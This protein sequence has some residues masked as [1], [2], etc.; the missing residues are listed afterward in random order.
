MSIHSKNAIVRTAAVCVRRTVGSLHRPRNAVALVRGLARYPLEHEAAHA[1]LAIPAATFAELFPEF[2]TANLTVS[3][4]D[5]DRHSWNVRLHEAIYLG[6]MVAALGARQIFE[7]GTFDGGTTRTLAEQSPADAVVHTIDLPESAFDA[8]QTPNGFTGARVGE[9]HRASPA[10]GKVRQIRADASS[11]DFE[12]FAAAMDFVFVDAAHDYP[13][14]V[15]DSRTALRLVRPGGVVVW[16][17]F[18]PY[19]SGL[20][21]AIC[22]ATAGRPL[23]KLSGTSMAVLRT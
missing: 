4:A 1:H 7:I 14:G 9:K 15:A 2:V 5:V 21:H 16:H 17:D 8:T 23:R 12:P 10:A 22:E 19:W 20:V 6:Q 18:E 13:H 3:R 11:F